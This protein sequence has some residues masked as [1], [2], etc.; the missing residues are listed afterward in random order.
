MM[1][2]DTGGEVLLEPIFQIAEAGRANRFR[3]PSA[4]RPAMLTEAAR[5]HSLGRSD[6][7]AL[8]QDDFR[9]ET[10]FVMTF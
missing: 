7:R 5:D 10:L 9:D 3:P 2:C 1:N 6:G 8:A 4:A